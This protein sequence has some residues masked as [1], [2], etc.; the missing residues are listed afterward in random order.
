[1][2]CVLC[3]EMYSSQEVFVADWPNHHRRHLENQQYIQQNLKD[4]RETIQT[5]ITA[6]QTVVPSA[7]DT[8][9]YTPTRED[10]G[11]IIKIKIE[12]FNMNT[13]KPLG[14]AFFMELNPVLD[15][16]KQ[17]L[18]SCPQFHQMRP[19]MLVSVMS[20]NL[21]ADI[22]TADYKK[23]KPCYLDWLYRRISIINEVRSYSPDI[24]C[25]QE[26]ESDFYDSFWKH[27]MK[28][29][30]YEGFYKKKTRDIFTNTYKMDGCATFYKGN[31][32]NLIG[33]HE[34]EF[35]HLS[36]NKIKKAFGNSIDNSAGV[37]RVLKDNI[38]LVLVLEDKMHRYLSMPKTFVIGNTHISANPKFPDVK[39]WQVQLYLNEI[40]RISKN[41]SLPMI[42]AGDYNSTPDSAAY[43]LLKNGYIDKNHSDLSAF[44]NDDEPELKSLIPHTNLFFTHSLNLNS[45][46]NGQHGEPAYTT[47]SA[48]DHFVG[49]LDYIFYSPGVTC[50]GN[51]DI[52]NTKEHIP[53]GIYPSDHF[54]IMSYFSFNG[55]TTR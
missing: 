23:V 11:K 48:M 4:Q 51:L 50:Y 44:K 46:Y 20:Y 35:K 16:K 28:K 49:T 5:T 14:P 34:I 21:L 43:Q 42:L 17:P 18:R 15:V 29:L 32:F 37:H 26:V 10:F 53:N 3:G 27:E 13:H 24:C 2:Q 41:G 45:A 25:F 39:L 8:I 33:K 31:R 1:M 38:G 54:S 55:S 52:P 12:P 19:D 30:G 22:Y 40:T 6:L 9:S 7:Q 36:L 47:R